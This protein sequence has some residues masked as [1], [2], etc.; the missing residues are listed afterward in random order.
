MDPWYQLEGDLF[1]QGNLVSV[2]SLE[3]SCPTAANCLYFDIS[4][5]L[6]LCFHYIILV[7]ICAMMVDWLFECSFIEC[8]DLHGGRM[9]LMEFSFY[10]C[11]LHLFFLFITIICNFGLILLRGARPYML[12]FGL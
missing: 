7:G 12:I 8:Q 6:M 4:I 5:S 9:N 3:E 10:S 11:Y 2:Y 1:K